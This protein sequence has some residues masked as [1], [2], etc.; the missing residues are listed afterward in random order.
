M[1]LSPSQLPIRRENSICGNS[2]QFTTGEVHV[3]WKTVALAFT[4]TLVTT[5][6]AVAK[7]ILPD[8]CGADKTGFDIKIKKDQPQPPAPDPDK[9]LIVFVETAMSSHFAPTFEVRFGLD[10]AWAG[11]TTGK[12]YFAVPIAPGEHHLCATI[13]SMYAKGVAAIDLTAEPGKVYYYEARVD[14]PT[15][16]APMV[17]GSGTPSQSMMASGVGGKFSFFFV[18]LSDAEGRYRVKAWPLSISTA[19]N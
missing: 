1:L 8:A 7:N 13:H 4:F 19:K 10:G 15:T 14:S 12:A 6:P 16:G 9:A 2:T 17:V 11:A 5:A 3:I 18:P